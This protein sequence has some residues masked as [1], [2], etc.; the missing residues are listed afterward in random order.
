MARPLA[1]ALQEHVV[2]WR[3]GPWPLDPAAVFGRR[4][5]LALEIGF[6]NGSF[7]EEQ[8]SARPDRD[9]LGVEL[10]WTAA[11]HLF[12]RLHRAGVTNVRVLL[13]EAEAIVRHALAPES[14]S[15]VFVNHP[16][17]WP[18]ARHVERRLLER[19][20]LA[21]LA[22]RMLPGAPLTVVTDHA[23]YAAWLAEE[24][25]A[26]PA[27][28]SRHATV[29]APEIAGRT[30]T[31]YQRKAMAQG[32]AIHYFEWQRRA[33][34]ATSPTVVAGG[35]R[36]PAPE[37]P[38]P[39]LTLRGAVPPAELFRDF[40]PVLFRERHQGQE[41]VVKFEAV[42]RRADRPVWLLETLV[43][44]DRLRQFFA[45]DVV[46][47]E[48]GI[49]LKPSAL[50][51]PYPTHGVKRAVWCAAQW[52]RSRHPGLEVRH[53]SLGLAPPAEPWPPA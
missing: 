10:S 45:L 3:R 16:C 26:T 18:K 11:T 21:E 30:P 31:K 9:H 15:E 41:V 12:R 1:L 20:F 14:L 48:D 34:L 39:T 17:P 32:I 43:Q 23:E 27:L 50:G 29:E 33:E 53:E 49:L 44:E 42:Y 46:A 13:G 38:M 24:L 19:G 36:D 4:A 22:T 28:V 52:L 47:R 2:E 25:V 7:L 37:S 35:D 8:A 5:P 40:R 51:D 6:G